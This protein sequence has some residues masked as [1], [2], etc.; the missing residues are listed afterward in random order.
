VKIKRLRA[1]VIITCTLYTWAHIFCVFSR[2]SIKCSKYTH[3]GVTYNRN[4]LKADFDKLSKE[5]EKL[6]TAYSQVI[7]KLASLDKYVK[8]LKKA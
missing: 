5:K 3:K 2:D 6:E 1:T 4:F 7:A 8:A